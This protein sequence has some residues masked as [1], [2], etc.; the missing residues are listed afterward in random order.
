MIFQNTNAP[1]M[2]TNGFSKAPRPGFAAQR[3]LPRVTLHRRSVGAADGV[4]LGEH[5]QVVPPPDTLIGNDSK[6]PKGEWR[7]AAD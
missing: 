5:L 4:R 7:Y 3:R 2:V 6:S 1:P